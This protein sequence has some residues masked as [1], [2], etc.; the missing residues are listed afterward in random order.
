MRS[1]IAPIVW[2][3]L[4]YTWPTFNKFPT[5]TTSSPVEKKA[6]LIWRYTLTFASP[7]EASS[8]ISD[9]LTHFPFFKI[10]SPFFTSSPIFLIL[11]PIL[12]L[13]FIEILS[14]S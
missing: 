3:L 13:S 5:S 2:L 8:P 6:T 10:N 12:G 9:D 1:N 7:R 11:A 4:S 14:P